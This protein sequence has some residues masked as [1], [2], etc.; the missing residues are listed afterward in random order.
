MT[1]PQTNMSNRLSGSRPKTNGSGPQIKEAQEAIEQHR[2]NGPRS[3]DFDGILARLHA[4]LGQLQN[5]S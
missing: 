3:I 5:P 1:K 4:A 2:A